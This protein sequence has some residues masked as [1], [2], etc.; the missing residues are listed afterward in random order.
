MPERLAVAPGSWEQV[1]E[2]ALVQQRR[3]GKLAVAL[4]QEVQVLERLLLLEQQAVE[5]AL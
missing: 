5:V 4:A 1:L 3:L 2:L